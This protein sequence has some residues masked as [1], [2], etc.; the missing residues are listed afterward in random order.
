MI[1]FCSFVEFSYLLVETKRQGTWTEQK[2]NLSLDALL[3]DSVQNPI[4]CSLRGLTQGFQ[5][6]Y[7]TVCRVLSKS[8]YFVWP[9]IMPDPARTGRPSTCNRVLPKYVSLTKGHLKPSLCIRDITY[10]CCLTLQLT[11]QCL[12]DQA[13]HLHCF[14][15]CEN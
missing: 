6:T 8:E 9:L 11:T 2:Q 7:S 15:F 10:R 3:L 14:V 13:S 1:F 5:G 12:V 4:R